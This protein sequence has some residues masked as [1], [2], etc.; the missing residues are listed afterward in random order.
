MNQER[1]EQLLTTID[2]LGAVKI[3]HLLRIHNDLRS[4]RNACRVVQQLEDY[5]HQTFYDREKVIY[6]NKEGRKLVASSKE[7]KKSPL[8][9][10]ILL[11]NEAYLYFGC[12]SDW[13]TEYSLETKPQEPD[14]TSLDVKING[15]GYKL[16][17]KKK[18]VADAVFTREWYLNIV[19]IDNT[20]NMIDNKRKIELYREVMKD[21]KVPKLWFFTTTD[22]RKRKL[23]EW[24]KGMRCEVR[25]FGEIL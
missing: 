2:R 16:I 10:H 23:L 19:E 9:E 24:M 18:V 8:L 1:K 6:L 25:T 11:R 14:P 7:V 15:G 21:L 13:K 20:R 12:P 3:K 22:D 17:N 5:T 4:Y